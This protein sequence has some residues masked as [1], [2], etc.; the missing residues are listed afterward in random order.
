[1]ASNDEES[2]DERE[3]GVDEEGNEIKKPKAKKEKKRWVKKKK[4]FIFNSPFHVFSFALQFNP[5]CV[6]GNF[7][8]K[9]QNSSKLLH[10]RLYYIYCDVKEKN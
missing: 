4:R 2:D 5:T 6:R 7:G 8:L 9:L 1:M 3:V 10:A